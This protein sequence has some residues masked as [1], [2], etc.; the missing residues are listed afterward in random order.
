MPD[1]LPPSPPWERCLKP[2]ALEGITLPNR[3]ALAPMAGITDY[4]FRRLAKRH[5]AGL[6]VSEMIASQALVRNSRRSGRMTAT[7]SRE[8]PLSVQISGTDPR[9]M[10]EA[11]RI[12]ESLG[13]A[14]IDINMGCPQPKVVKTGGGAALMRNEALAARIMEAV[15]AAVAVPVTLKIRLG[16]D[17]QCLN[18]SRIAKI[19]QEA[20]I[21]LVT[22]HC[23]TR[24]QMFSGK[25]DWTALRQVRKAVSIPVFANGDIRDAAEARL[26]LDVSGA[27]GIMVGR[28][29]LGRP[30]IFSMI[31]GALGPQE[32][33]TVPDLPSQHALVIEHFENILEFYGSPI[34][35]PMARKHLAW[36]AKGL[37][38]GCR[39]RQSINSAE[40]PAEVMDLLNGFYRRLA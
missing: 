32:A 31:L 30:W 9:I 27:E 23:R 10:A 12:N 29:A 2:L 38:G 8:Y 26:C 5:G 35:L 19:A 20:G 15:K 33:Q 4:P 40:T 28:G 3:I 34:G 18:A 25:A 36:Y 1:P 21:A 16:W 22:V 13:A 24:S 37:P 39:F 14:L 11:A 7:A 17:R 6:I